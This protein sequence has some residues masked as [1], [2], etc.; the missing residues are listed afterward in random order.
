MYQQGENDIAEIIKKTLENLQLA[1]NMK[2]DYTEVRNKLTLET[3]E[4]ADGDS[5]ILAAVFIG[6]TRLIDNME[7]NG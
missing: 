3:Q 5:I 6:N 2:I 7:F 1:K 4:R